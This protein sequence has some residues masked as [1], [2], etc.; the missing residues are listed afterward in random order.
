MPAWY[1]CQV[2]YHT[3]NINDWKVTLAFCHKK[4]FDV[5]YSNIYFYFFLSFFYLL[6]LVPQ[7]S[8]MEEFYQDAEIGPVYDIKFTSLITDV[9]K[10]EG[11]NGLKLISSSQVLDLYIHEFVMSR[12]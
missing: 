12:H 9:I 8:K 4:K 3:D 10:V 5:S 7:L 6:Y 1:V 11:T 2:F